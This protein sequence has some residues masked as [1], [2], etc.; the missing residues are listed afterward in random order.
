MPESLSVSPITE[1][2]QGGGTSAPS[3]ATPSLVSAIGTPETTRRSLT[4]IASAPAAPR[5]LSASC[6]SRFVSPVASID[7]HDPRPVDRDQAF[8]RTQARGFVAQHLVRRATAT[9]PQRRPP[10]RQLGL[11]DG[12]QVVAAVQVVDQKAERCGVDADQAPL[13]LG[14]AADLDRRHEGDQERDQPHADPG[15][16][17]GVSPEVPRPG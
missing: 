10:L 3:T 17:V 15:Q 9:R 13:D 1:I 4:S 14:L 12:Q 6:R 7:H 16:P 5:L 11:L 8:Q 2:L